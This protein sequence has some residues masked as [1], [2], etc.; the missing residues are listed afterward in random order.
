MKTL[1]GILILV[2]IIVT[3][4]ACQ[5]DSLKPEFE[6]TGPIPE[7]KD[8]PSEGQKI[9]YELYQ[10]YDLHTYYT[11]SGDD[12]LRT[13]IGTTQTN[14][15]MDG[16][17]P[18]QAGDVATSTSF[19]KFF[20]SFYDL[21][22]EELAKSSGVRRNVLVKVN[23]NLDMLMYYGIMDPN[24]YKINFTETMQGIALWGDMDDEIGIQPEA[25]KY[26]LCYTYFEART[27]SYYHAELP[28]LTDFA[29]VATYLG[30]M[31]GDELKEAYALMA[32]TVGRANM[33]YLYSKGF[34][35]PNG[36][37]MATSKS[38]THID[39]ATYA[40]WIACKSL[41]E[42]QEIMEKNLL[43]ERKYELT[44]R[45]YKDNLNLDLEDFAQKLSNV[46]IE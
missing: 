10:K 40:T 29:A 37:A 23:P 41:A 31:S 35:D 28:A 25:W 26:S 6:Y 13:E 14:M 43:V 27:A 3:G 33:E 5:E 38:S 9:C 46:I 18:P 16:T 8:G 39:M 42:R 22:P 19:L 15:M 7:I 21:L 12:A 1:Y 11:L 36:F 4:M 17:Y 44:L 34:V 20:K 24:F 2:G 32:D 45:Y 30:E